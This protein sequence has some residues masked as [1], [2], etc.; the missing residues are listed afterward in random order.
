MEKCKV[1]AGQLEGKLKL[2][3][4]LD[5]EILNICNVG[6]IQNEIEEAAEISDGILDVVRIIGEKTKASEEKSSNTNAKGSSPST[7]LDQPNESENNVSNVVNV[8]NSSSD[9]NPNNERNTVVN[10]D[11]ANEVTNSSLLSNPEQI[12]STSFV[13]LAGSLPKLPKLQLPKF[14]G[15]VTEWNSFWDSFDS[16][17]HIS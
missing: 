17:I 15:K 6:E 14:S 8:Q 1:I 3:S 4:E 7:S 11:L 2:L 5:N 13:H 12:A 16:A 9:S 10:S